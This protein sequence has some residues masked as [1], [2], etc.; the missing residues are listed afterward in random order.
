MSGGTFNPLPQEQREEPVAVV[1]DSKTYELLND[2]KVQLQIMNLYLS[3]LTH[4]NINER[5]VR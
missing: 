2:I 5:D 3:S 1:Y 4:Q